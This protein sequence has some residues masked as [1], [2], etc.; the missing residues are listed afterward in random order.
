VFDGSKTK[1]DTTAW[2]QRISSCPEGLIDLINSRACRSA[3]MFND[4]LSLQECRELVRKLCECIFPFMCAHG[5]P[6][7]VP[8]ID[9]G[10]VKTPDYTPRPGAD[11]TQGIELGG[12]FAGAWKRWQKKT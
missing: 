4:E 11:S 5:R 6:S 8:L 1:D 7:M 10:A 3:I 9:I 2:V 12:G